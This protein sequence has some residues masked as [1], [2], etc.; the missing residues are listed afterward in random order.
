[1]QR[2]AS[3][4]RG[5]GGQWPRGPWILGGPSGGPWA[6]RGQ[7]EGPMGFI[8]TSKTFFFGDYLNLDRKSLS[9]SVK[10]PPFFLFLRSLE[11]PEK[12]VPFSLPVLDCTKPE[13][14]NIWV[15]PGPPSALGAP[16]ATSDSGILLGSIKFDKELPKSCCCC[17]IS[18]QTLFG[19]FWA[20]IW[21]Q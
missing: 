13:M 2:R 19:G 4:R 6:W 10:A 7:W 21:S 18:N 20:Q 17:S 3:E 9:I 1:M 11:N 5:Q 12:S 14:R 8:G 16:D 15:V